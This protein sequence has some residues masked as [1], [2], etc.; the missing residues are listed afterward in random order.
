ME[1]TGSPLSSKVL[2]CQPIRHLFPRSHLTYFTVMWRCHTKW[3]H[4]DGGRV[5]CSTCPWHQKGWT[6][7]S[8][9]SSHH[10]LSVRCGTFMMF[11]SIQP[12]LL[13]YGSE[14]DV[15]PRYSLASRGDFTTVFLHCEAL[16]LPYRWRPA[17]VSEPALCFH[18]QDHDPVGSGGRL[19]GVG[20]AGQCLL[21]VVS[22][23]APCSP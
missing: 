10:S 4:G 22:Q 1:S 9:N 14:E 15:S 5:I 16:C 21:L 20:G 23:T 12:A 6:L 17:P 8:F 7:N 3:F 19:R 11:L 18:G 13:Y 2:Y